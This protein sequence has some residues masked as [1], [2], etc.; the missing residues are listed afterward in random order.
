VTFGR[1]ELQNDMSATTSLLASLAGAPQ[2]QEF[3]G[4]AGDWIA[5]LQRL[6]HDG[7]AVSLAAGHAQEWAE[8]SFANERLEA[9]L[10]AAVS[11][12]DTDA[13]AD[14]AA[15]APVLTSGSGFAAA[16][17]DGALLSTEDLPPA[18]PQ[19]AGR[20][21]AK[22]H[23]AVRDA[24][25]TLVAVV[26]DDFLCE[27]ARVRRQ[28]TGSAWQRIER[29]APAI[30]APAPDEVVDLVAECAE[31]IAR[32]FGLSFAASPRSARHE[33]RVLT[34]PVAR[35]TTAQLAPHIDSPLHTGHEA[36][37]DDRDEDCLDGLPLN[38]GMSSV[39]GLSS[40]WNRT[41]TALMRLR[42]GASLGGGH[43]RS[44]LSTRGEWFE[45]VVATT[46][47]HLHGGATHLREQ[48]IM[49]PGV[50]APSLADG[51]AFFEK[52]LVAPYAYNRHVA[53]DSRRLHLA[54]ADPLQ[55]ARLAVLGQDAGAGRLSLNSFLLPP[56]FEWGQSD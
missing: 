35:Q 31:P 17:R 22:S 2:C 37:C 9:A 36:E 43:G 46:Q 10:V 16:D 13:N 56:G 33:L 18:Q 19:L 7:D 3:N 28:A 51:N 14:G 52:L 29:G 54:A 34:R 47:P 40:E 32:L 20:C 11:F 23:T 41:G 25:G 21:C 38:R 12:A 48:L 5:P 4:R 55:A 44:L 27:P 45:L 24:E 42:P 8:D 1:A 50:T 49:P 15:L 30:R 26:T 53:Y 39:L 6:I